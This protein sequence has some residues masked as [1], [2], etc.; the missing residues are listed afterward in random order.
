MPLYHSDKTTAGD[1]NEVVLT[2]ESTGDYVDIDDRTTALVNIGYAHHKIHESNHF[3]SAK[4]VDLNNNEVYDF[5]FICG[6]GPKKSHFVFTI[7]ATQLTEI[8]LY[9]GTTYTGGFTTNA[10]CNDRQSSNTS[11]LQARV[12]ATVTDYGTNIWEAKI[13]SGKGIGVASNRSEFILKN[14]TNYAFYIKS[15][16]PANS[17]TTVS[18]WYDH[19]D[20]A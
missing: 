2:Q 17:V 14:N 1:R 18:E 13:S 15:L 11:I 19:E 12:G 8:I 9:E 10:F 20:N 7:Q 6:A 3:Y 16:S 5:V 4:Y